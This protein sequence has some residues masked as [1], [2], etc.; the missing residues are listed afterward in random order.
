M[1]WQHLATILG[2][3]LGVIVV[4]RVLGQREAPSVTIAWLVVILFVPYVGVPLYVLLGTRKLRGA[5]RRKAPIYQPGVARTDATA[6]R[7]G[8]GALLAAGGQPPARGGHRVTLARDGEDA[9]RRLLAALH[10]AQ[11]SIWICTF[12]LQRD[13]VGRALLEVLAERARAGVDVRLL[14]DG[15]GSWRTRGRFTKILRAAGGHVAIFHPVW[16][17]AR[18]WSANLRNHRKSVLVD[19]QRTFLGGMNLG[20]HYLGPTPDPRRW[21]DTLVE[22]VGPAA[23]DVGEVFRRDWAFAAEE[24]LPP[25]RPAPAAGA[26]PVR[27]VASGPDTPGD[28]LSDVLTLALVGARR[29]VWA[30]TPYLVPDE[31]ILHALALA[32]RQGADVRIVLPRR[33]DHVLADLARGHA[34]RSLVE[35]GARILLHPERMVHAKLFVFD[36]E[37]GMVGS[38]NLDRRSL[39]LNYEVTALFEGPAEVSALAAWTQR[40]MDQCEEWTPRPENAVRLLVEDVTAI[41]APLI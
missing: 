24:E 14:L 36:D 3:V 16:I 38:A 29:R 20:A 4:A 1:A 22:V 31:T 39:Y 21:V 5:L 25:V 6:D 23:A 40:L 2:L 41:L 13:A 33:S 8:V 12:Q 30:V 7:F 35:A 9:W 10:G 15:M 18:P 11:T 32:A 17:L 28:P 27:V 34:L 37:L 19:G 26:A